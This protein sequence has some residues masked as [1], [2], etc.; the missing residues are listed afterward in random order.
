MMTLKT[1]QL[2]LKKYK[3]RLAS[4]YRVKSLAVFG[5]FAYGHPT[6]QS[7]IDILVDF[8]R[9]PDLFEFIEVETYLEKILG[10]KVDLVR[11][12]MLRDELRNITEHAVKI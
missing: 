7:D 2:R 3:S 9:T 10:R 4:R 12:Q 6:A 8:K 1:I 5:S 11:S